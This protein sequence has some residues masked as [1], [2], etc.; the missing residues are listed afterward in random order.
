MSNKMKSA[1]VFPANQKFLEQLGENLKLACKRRKYTQT[2]LSERTGLSRMTL[3][4][5][6]NGEPTVSIGHYVMVLGVL[7]LAEDI[8]KVAQD[9]E[10]G[11]KLQ[12]IALLKNRR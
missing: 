7:G 1:T 8:S 10:L 3:R 11:Y 9:D 6:M 12:N 4:K 2:L 5:I